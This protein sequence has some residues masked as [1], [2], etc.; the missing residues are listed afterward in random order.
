MKF[1]CISFVSFIC[2]IQVT[3][4]SLQTMLSCG[5]GSLSGS[6]YSTTL[7]GNPLFSNSPSLAVFMN[8]AWLS[9][10]WVVTGASNV[11]GSD[12]LGQY[13]GTECSYSLST[14]P[15]VTFFTTAAYTYPSADAAPE[16][17]I[18]RF[19]YSFPQ[20]IKE[21]NHSANKPATY[22]TVS[23][24]PSFKG[25]NTPLKDILTWRDAFFGPSNNIPDSLGQIASTIV[26]FDG[27]DVASKAV[28]LSP[29]DV[30]LNAALG[31]DLGDGTACSGSDA[32][33]WV[34]GVSATVTSLPPGFTQSYV[35]VSATGFTSTV[36]AWGSVLRAYYG[37][38]SS[39]LSDVSLSTLGYQTDNVSL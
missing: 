33:C 15:A 39:R 37:G 30:F 20:G 36:N 26:F 7:D 1:V 29:L 3:T 32:G 16:S 9:N 2:L 31:D 19:R 23:N 25:P 14:N 13:T 24:F 18:V 4:G 27:S 12:A 11:S 17:S 22:S 34:G 5:S 35:L 10:S 38:T 6:M 21:T 28:V 8:G